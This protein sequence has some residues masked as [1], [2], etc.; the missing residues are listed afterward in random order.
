M[1]R[2]QVSAKIL[3]VIGSPLGRVMPQSLCQSTAEQVQNRKNL[4]STYWHLAQA[5]P[6]ACEIQVYKQYR[7]WA[8]KAVDV[9]HIGLLGFGV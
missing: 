5:S 9:T 7:H 2:V 6:T 3:D 8:L 1:E 4:V